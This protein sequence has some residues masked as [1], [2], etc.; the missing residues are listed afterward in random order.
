M[1][2]PAIKHS[3][4]IK[5]SPETVYRTITTSEGWN[6]W[7]TDEARI[8]PKPGGE[9]YFKW[10]N[11]GCDNLTFEDH[12]PVLEA[13]PNEKFVF[14]W[15]PGV[16]QTTCTFIL[17]PQDDGTLISFTEEGYT[18]DPKDLQMLV[19]CATG[20]GEAL[21]LLKIYLEHGI[22]YKYSDVGG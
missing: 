13:I 16:T 10:E 12:G 7:F 11:V 21:T 9:I 19:E 6:A 22:A 1:N 4:Y 17:N 20:W 3:V 15:N 8:D 2:L 5:A 14:K 18:E